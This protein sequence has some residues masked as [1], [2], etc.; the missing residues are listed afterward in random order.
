MSAFRLRIAVVSR[1]GVTDRLMLTS[2]PSLFQVGS[3]LE[4]D[5]SALLVSNT[6]A[7]SLLTTGSILNAANNLESVN[8]TM[9]VRT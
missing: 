2:L 4:L 9:V 6:G 5:T 1:S 7:V 8:D 3:T